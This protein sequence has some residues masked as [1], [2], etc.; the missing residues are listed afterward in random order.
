M[1]FKQNHQ[2]I[3]S[4]YTKKSIKDV[5][6]SGE[7][8]LSCFAILFFALL[9]V[10]GYTNKISAICLFEYSSTTIKHILISRSLKSHISSNL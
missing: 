9:I 1:D 3:S 2:K 10:F 4:T 8:V 5:R 7:D 6:N